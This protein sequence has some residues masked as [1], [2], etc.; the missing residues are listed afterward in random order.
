MS[1]SPNKLLFYLG[2]EVLKADGVFS[3]GVVGGQWWAG[4]TIF[5]AVLCCIL[6]KAALIT[7]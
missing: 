2:V 4:T 7:E 6:W 1:F 5:S 3:N